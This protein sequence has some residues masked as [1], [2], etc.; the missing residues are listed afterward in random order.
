VNFAYSTLLPGGGE[1]GGRENFVPLQGWEE[2]KDLVA[3]A[4][5]DYRSWFARHQKKSDLLL[6]GIPTQGVGWNRLCSPM[7]GKELLIFYF[8]DLN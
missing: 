1:S 4:N 2:G 3:Q 8:N 6:I 7:P 5:G